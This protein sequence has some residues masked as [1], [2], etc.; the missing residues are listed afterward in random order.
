MSRFVRF[1]EN[2]TKEEITRKR[3]YEKKS[4]FDFFMKYDSVMSNIT[5]EM[6]RVL[7]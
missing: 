1:L 3:D 6:M 2:I 4:S 7:K 5:K